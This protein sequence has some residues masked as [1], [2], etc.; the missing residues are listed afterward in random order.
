[1]V[2]FHMARGDKKL[3]HLQNVPLFRAC[4]KKELQHIGRAAEEIEVPKGKV[5]CREGDIGHEFFLVLEGEATVTKKGK[6]VNTI[7]P[8]AAFGEMALLDKGPRTA[9][10][11]AKTPMKLVVLAQ[12]EFSGVLD[13]IPGIAHKMLRA[14]SARLRETDTKELH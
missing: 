8:G 9:T 10:I 11:E 12:R 2:R 13:E 5:L 7:G 14:L 4:S 3:D 6:K 1:M